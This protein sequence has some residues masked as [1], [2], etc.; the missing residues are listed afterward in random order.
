M[1]PCWWD[2]AVF[3]KPTTDGTFQPMEP[4]DIMAIRTAIDARRTTKRPFDIVTGGPTPDRDPAAARAKLAPLAEAG[5][6]VWHEFL[7]NDPRAMRRRI[8]VGSPPVAIGAAGRMRAAGFEPAL[9]AV[10]RRLW[11]ARVLTRLD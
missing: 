4:E 1:A 3:Y 9:R 6:T 10:C 11:Q 7:P 5:L 2:R 8:E